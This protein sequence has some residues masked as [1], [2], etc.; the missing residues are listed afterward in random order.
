MLEASLDGL[1]GHWPGP[2]QA[3]VVASRPHVRWPLTI[4]HHIQANLSS[5][6]LFD[7]YT[8]R[9]FVAKAPER[10]PFGTDETPAKFADFDIY[11]KVRTHHRTPLYLRY[12]TNSLSTD[13]HPPTDDPVCHDA[14]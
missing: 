6:E 9:Q 14:A 10:N 1:A 11:T 7:E 2:A 3:P 12:V 4:A 13:P 8:R 5:H